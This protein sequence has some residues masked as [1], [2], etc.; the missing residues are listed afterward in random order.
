MASIV[1][2][3]ACSLD[4]FIADDTGGVSWLEAFGEGGEDFGYA[5]FLQQVGTL[6]M[7]GRTYRQVFGF[8]EWPY[9]GKRTLVFTGHP[10]DGSKP[11]GVEFRH[12]LTTAMLEA[13]RTAESGLIWLV[14]G[15]NLIAQV[16]RLGGLDSCRIFIMPIVLGA[17]VALFE[18]GLRLTGLQLEQATRHGQGVVELR[19]QL[20]RRPPGPGA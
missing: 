20:G 11:P 13:L 5:N 14:G 9:A 12:E 18:P 3:I 8:G 10:G 16:I 7:G 6:L 15:A 2:Y 17:G 4:G 1:L 19:Y